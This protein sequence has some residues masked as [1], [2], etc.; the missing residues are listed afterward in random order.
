ML[1]KGHYKADFKA[2]SELL[3][4]LWKDEEELSTSL[5]MSEFVSDTFDSCEINKDDLCKEMRELVLDKR[6]NLNPEQGECCG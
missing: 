3:F 6:E 1:Q 5:H 2:E 4:A